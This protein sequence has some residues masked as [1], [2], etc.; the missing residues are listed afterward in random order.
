MPM[1]ASMTYNPNFWPKK[2]TVLSLQ[3]RP[4]RDTR[5]DRVG[6]IETAFQVGQSSRIIPEV[7][8]LIFLVIFAYYGN[9]GS[10]IIKRRQEQGNRGKFAL[11][12]PQT[13]IS[14]SQVTQTWHRR[15]EY[16]FSMSHLFKIMSFE[17]T[18]PLFWKSKCA[19][20]VIF[21]IFRNLTLVRE[22]HNH[23]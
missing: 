16:E 7:V 4:E 15:Y 6:K 10:Q 20:K 14:F 21:H 12:V 2:R 23:N 13:D 17:S 19:L 3:T 9:N 22:Q 5:Q 18:K 8:F 1:G 11:V